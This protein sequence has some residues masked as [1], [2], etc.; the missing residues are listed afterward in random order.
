MFGSDDTRRLNTRLNAA[1]DDIGRL[2]ATISRIETEW[3][4]TK[5]QVRKSY[6]RNE[7]AVSRLK[8]VQDRQ[9]PPDHTQFELEAPSEPEN[10]H[11]AKVLQIRRESG[12]V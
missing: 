7:R 10:A 11:M 9:A 1:L 4:E 3:A 8:V 12:A 6:Q 5:D 2:Q